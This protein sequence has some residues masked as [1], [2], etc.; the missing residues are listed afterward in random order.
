MCF[1]TCNLNN[2]KLCLLYHKVKMLCKSDI[3]DVNLS[4]CVAVKLN[5][6][7]LID[8]GTARAVVVNCLE[9]K[10]LN[11]PKTYLCIANCQSYN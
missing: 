9:T 5:C 2:I 8:L 4:P 7:N 10:G 1:V 6:V 11:S 3:C